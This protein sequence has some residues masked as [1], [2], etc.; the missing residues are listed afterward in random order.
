MPHLLAHSRSP[1]Q[2]HLAYSARGALTADL[3]TKIKRLAELFLGLPPEVSCV[4]RDLMLLHNR[5]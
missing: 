2:S 1:F 4:Y 5:Y 3:L